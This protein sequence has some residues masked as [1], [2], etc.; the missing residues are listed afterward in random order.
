MASAN[1]TTALKVLS[2]LVNYN[3]MA[4]NISLRV[5]G[6]LVAVAIAVGL[7]AGRVIFNV[8]ADEPAKQS[9][10]AT[11]RPSAA[12]VN[13]EQRQNS[14][15]TKVLDGDTVV[16]EGGEHVRLL[17]IDADEAG[18]PCYEAAKKRLEDLILAKPV[19][20]EADAGDKDQYGRLLRYIFINN[21]NINEQLVAEGLAIARFYPENQKY[22]AEITSAEA[23]AIKNKT[24]CK[25]AGLQ[26]GN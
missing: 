22:K 18:Y 16:V 15:V 19:I 5:I 20:L 7:Y 26:A 9:G 13:I 24:G 21:Q 2:T 23:N 6:A 11:L 3:S 4:K 12:A 8:P 1:G 14:I 10:Q 25:W 17:G